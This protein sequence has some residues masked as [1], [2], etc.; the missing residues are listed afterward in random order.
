[1]SFLLTKQKQELIFKAHHMAEIL[2]CKKALFKVA[3]Y[4]NYAHPCDWF[5]YMCSFLSTMKLIF[6]I[7]KILVSFWQIH[8]VS[9][10]VLGQS[11]LVS[12]C[13]FCWQL[14]FGERRETIKKLRAFAYSWCRGGFFIILMHLFKNRFIVETQEFL[15]LSGSPLK[16][17]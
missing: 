15:L 8:E 16:Y 7:W 3:F 14:L 4:A 9:N 11:C 2:I 13:V 10:L 6:A 5:N 12:L 1:M 17:F